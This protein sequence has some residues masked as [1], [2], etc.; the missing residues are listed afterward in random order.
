M[1]SIVMLTVNTV[2]EAGDI[3]LKTEY[4]KKSFVL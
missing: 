1:T 2:D 3:D 4:T